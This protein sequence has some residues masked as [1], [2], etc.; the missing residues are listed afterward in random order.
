VTRDD[1]RRAGRVEAEGKLNLFLRVLAREPSGYHQLS[2]LFQ[3]VALADTVLV[4]TGGTGRALDLRGPLHFPAQ[5]NIAWHAAEAYIAATGWRAGL[6]RASDR[7]IP[8]RGGMG[9]GGSDAAAG[10]RILNT[11]APW[12]LDAAALYGIAFQLGADVPYLVS[13][14]PLALGTGRG[15]RLRELEPLPSREVVLWIPNFGVASRHAF[16]WYAAS[17]EEARTAGGATDPAAASWAL[18]MPLT[19]ADVAEQAVNDLESPVFDHHPELASLL[20]RLGESSPLMARMSGS[21]ST[22]FAV[23]PAAAV[24]LSPPD[25]RAVTTKTVERVASVEVIG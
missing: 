3:R 15:E 14:L 16:A 10:L 7:G 19:W 12:P 1:S 17:R 11:L 22:L 4:R 9:G 5:D 6:P 24:T 23:Y 18:P 25:C 13:E 8:L 21:G 20:A 2:T